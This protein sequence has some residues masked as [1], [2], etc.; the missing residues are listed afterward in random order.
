MYQI[1]IKFVSNVCDLFAKL[2]FMDSEQK[3]A[4]QFQVKIPR[5]FD[6]LLIS[7][8]ET[9]NQSMQNLD[10]PT[11]PATESLR[12]PILYSPTLRACSMWILMFRVCQPFR[13]HKRYRTGVLFTKVDLHSLCESLGHFLICIRGHLR[14]IK[15]SE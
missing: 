12:I 11:K 13:C 14:F 7:K 3:T 4:T 2:G 10:K 5:Y 9:L 15:Y 1:C 6:N 8:F